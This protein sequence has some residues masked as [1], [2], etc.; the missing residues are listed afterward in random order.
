MVTKVC[1]TSVQTGIPGVQ[2]IRV[3]GRTQGKLRYLV[4]GGRSHCVCN[5]CIKDSAALM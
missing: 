5:S 3:H 4:H 1:E 2:L